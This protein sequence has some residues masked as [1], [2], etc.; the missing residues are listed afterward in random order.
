MRM[1][2]FRLHRTFVIWS[3]AA[4]FLQLHDSAGQDN[5]VVKFAAAQK[6]NASELKMYRWSSRTELN[7]K[8]ETK[9][10]RVESIS[11]NEAGQLQKRPLQGT[12][13]QGQGSDVDK[14]TAALVQGLVKLA[15]S[16]AYLSDYQEK[17]LKQNLKVSGGRG[18]IEEAVQLAA[19]NVVQPGDTV[20]I[21]ANAS[22]LLINR[23]QIYTTY[24]A[25]SVQL[26]VQYSTPPGGPAYPVRIEMACPAKGV[27]INIVYGDFE[28][29][30]PSAPVATASG[31][32]GKP[33]IGTPLAEPAEDPGWPRVIEHPS[34]KLLAYQPQVDEWKDFKEITWRM[35]LS[36][37]PSGGKTVIGAA[38][39]HGLTDVDHENHTVLLHDMTIKNTYFPSVDSAAGAKLSEALKAFL[40]PSLTA[41]LERVVACTPKNEKIRPVALKNDPPVIF[42]AYKPSMLIDTDGDPVFVPVPKTSLEFVLNT[43]W[44]IF[45]D[46][47]DGHLYLYAAEQW[48]SAATVKGPWSR[49]TKLPSEMDAVAKDEHWAYLASV[50]PLKAPKAGTVAPQIFLTSTPAD[51]ILFEGQPAYVPVIG[52]Q[53]SYATNTVSYVFRHAG[54]NQLYYLTSG[55]WFSAAKLEG[56]WTF[57]SESL[58]E[59]FAKIPPDS[60]A[61]RS[62][63]LRPGH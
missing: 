7:V 9:G 18:D 26:M 57:A 33:L 56:P 6:K 12:P 40:P 28:F 62:P 16:Y 4:L 27:Q 41:S 47:A 63:G 11:F 44:D 13:L 45:R 61:A 48:L 17:Y 30:P 20:A 51:L 2:S 3:L 25:D 39:I 38:T 34:G 54:K 35:A 60:P 1:R 46:K 10:V 29:V 8:G 37:T 52:T 31:I 49:A 50:I 42:V 59:D 23:V 58:P 24:E 19:Q 22:N 55:R 36:V 21:W 43:R 5:A 15:Q 14:A 32:S 53:L